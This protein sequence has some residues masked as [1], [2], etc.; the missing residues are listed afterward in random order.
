MFRYKIQYAISTDPDYRPGQSAFTT[1]T[2]LND[3]I[4][5]VQSQTVSHA[6][7]MV[8]AMNGGPSRCLVK[9]VVPA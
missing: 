3:L 5:E 1:S 7:A 2:V 8:E 9:V 4:I 6:R